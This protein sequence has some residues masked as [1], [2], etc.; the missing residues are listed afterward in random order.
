MTYIQENC[1][2]GNIERFL[3]ANAGNWLLNGVN[4]GVSLFEIAN[5]CLEEKKRRPEMV[6]VKDLLT[7]LIKDID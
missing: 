5:K 6:Q 4:F 3:D 7:G 1:E 2:D